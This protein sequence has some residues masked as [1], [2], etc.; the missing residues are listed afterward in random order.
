M[1]KRPE[2]ARDKVS[3]STNSKSPP[4][5]MPEANLVIFKSGKSRNNRTRYAAVASPSVFGSVAR[6]TSR[7]VGVSS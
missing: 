7:M 3:S 2:S 5:G 1:V 4:S 6:M